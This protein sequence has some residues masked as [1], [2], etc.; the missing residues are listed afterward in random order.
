MVYNNNNITNGLLQLLSCN[1]QQR[2]YSDLSKDECMHTYHDASPSLLF[3][4]VM[5]TIPACSYSDWALLLQL[6]LGLAG[7]CILR[8]VNWKDWEAVQCLDKMEVVERIM[9]PICNVGSHSRGWKKPSPWCWAGC[10][11]YPT[12]C[13]FGFHWRWFTCVPSNNCIARSLINGVVVER[14][15]NVI[16]FQ[17]HVLHTLCFRVLFASLSMCSWTTKEKYAKTSEMGEE[18]VLKQESLNSVILPF[19]EDRWVDPACSVSANGSI[20]PFNFNALR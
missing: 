20:S 15:I 17:F 13:G 3:I 19:F 7:I 16:S 10:R 2:N 14:T 5:A 9:Y 12:S 18:I 4:M 6:L 11:P 8:K 1:V